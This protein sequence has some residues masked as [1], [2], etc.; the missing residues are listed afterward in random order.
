MGNRGQKEDHMK[1]KHSDVLNMEGD[2]MKSIFAN[3]AITMNK[4]NKP[5]PSTEPRRAQIIKAKKPP[6]WAGEKFEKYKEQV[7]AWDDANKADDYEKYMDLLENLKKND[8]TKQFVINVI[9]EKTAKKEDKTV[10]K[11]MAIMEEKFGRTKTEK[12]NDILNKILEFSVGDEESHEEYWDKFEKLL[13]NMKG[14]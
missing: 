12:F 1:D 5:K 10:K 2:K 11:I 8:L 4:Y 9:I 13:S 3:I 7:E 6:S 14:E